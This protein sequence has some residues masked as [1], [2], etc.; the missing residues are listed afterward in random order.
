VI[1]FVKVAVSFHKYQFSNLY[2]NI[3]FK[4]ELE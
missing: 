3:V 2:K 1:Q 4:D